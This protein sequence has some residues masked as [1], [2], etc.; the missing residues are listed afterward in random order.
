MISLPCRLGKGDDP[1]AGVR[2]RRN[3]ILRLILVSPHD[4]H[5]RNHVFRCS[6]LVSMFKRHQ[7]LCFRSHQTSISLSLPKCSPIRSTNFMSTFHD[8]AVLHTLGLVWLSTSNTVVAISSTC[9]VR[10]YATGERR[11]AAARTKFV[12]TYFSTVANQL[13]YN[14]LQ[15]TYR[16][17]IDVL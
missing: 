9:D 7:H 1:K 12:S 13:T 5:R 17:V 4:S 14:S 8:A 16:E 3:D 2:L 10:S 11:F 6:G 15:P